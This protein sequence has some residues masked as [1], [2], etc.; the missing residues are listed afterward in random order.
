M[1]FAFWSE[2]IRPADLLPARY[3]RLPDAP[4][5]P[6]MQP[7]AKPDSLRSVHAAAREAHALHFQAWDI[8]VARL[9]Q[10]LQGYPELDAAVLAL[11]HQTND[12]FVKPLQDIHWRPAPS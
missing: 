6:P 3:L 9:H 10:L 8:F 5:P 4:P 1:P 12:S 7:V 2:L 11:L